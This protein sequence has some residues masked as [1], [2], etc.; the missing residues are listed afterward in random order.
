MKLF[1]A[2][3]L[4][5]LFG[6]GLA[7]TDHQARVLERNGQGNENGNGGNGNGNGNGNN[8]DEVEEFDPSA[9]PLLEEIATP[10]GAV[11][12]FYEADSGAL[13]VTSSIAQDAGLDPLT[14]YQQQGQSKKD[15]GE[16]YERV[17][18]QKPTG[19]I[20]KA[21]NRLQKN[22]EMK[23]EIE[24]WPDPPEAVE[25]AGGEDS[26]GHNRRKLNDWWI[27]TYCRFT[28]PID[29]CVCGPDRTQETYFQK[30]TDDYF[31]TLLLLYPDG[32]SIYQSI[33]VWS[34]SG[35]WFWRSCE[36]KLLA[37]GRTSLNRVATLWAEAGSERWYRGRVY[38]GDRDGIPRGYHVSVYDLVDTNIGCAQGGGGGCYLCP[39]VI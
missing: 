37:L 23:H 15:V 39:N 35:R 14:E 21:L 38:D 13:V 4:Y 5:S 24:D 22:K 7:D 19:S 27:Q 18:G 20:K 25:V 16:F 30:E 17:T 9:D 8:S 28:R 12:R 1:K 10:E 26:E 33:E 34:C 3:V 36:W 2:I 32:Q 6:A 11:V 29:F 31:Q